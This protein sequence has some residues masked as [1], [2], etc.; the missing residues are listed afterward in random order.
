MFGL[1]RGRQ[2]VVSDLDLD[3]RTAEFASNLNGGSI[4]EGWILIEW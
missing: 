3:F 1:K 2:N 4:N